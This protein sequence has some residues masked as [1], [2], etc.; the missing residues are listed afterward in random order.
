MRPPSLPRFPHPPQLSLPP[1][2]QDAWGVSPASSVSVVSYC[3]PI[4]NSSASIHA[5]ATSVTP[6]GTPSAAAPTPP[7]AP[8]AGNVSADRSTRDHRVGVRAKQR[9]RRDHA[10]PCFGYGGGARDGWR[11]QHIHTGPGGQCCRPDMG[12]ERGRRAVRVGRRL[13]TA[14]AVPSDG[15]ADGFVNESGARGGEGDC[16]EGVADSTTDNADTT[17]SDGGS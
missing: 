1:I 14:V 8:P 4:P 16:V 15:P 12:S 9:N 11:Y 2:V 6:C 3:R 17:A 5:G 7:S 10:R 13:C